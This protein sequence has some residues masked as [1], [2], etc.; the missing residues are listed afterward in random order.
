MDKVSITN[1]AIKKFPSMDLTYAQLVT[2]GN[3]PYAK[4]MTMDYPASSKL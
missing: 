4:I 1:P 2:H 3:K